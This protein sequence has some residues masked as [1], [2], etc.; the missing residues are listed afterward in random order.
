VPTAS[1]PDRFFVEFDTPE[2][3][4]LDFSDD[5]VIVLFFISWA[6]SAE[7]GGTHE[8]ALAANHL[9]RSLKVDV[10]PLYKYAD[11][12]IDTPQDQQEFDRAWQPASELAACI[13]TVADHW[14]QPDATLAPLIEGYLHL[15][16]R[17]RELAA[18]CD[19]AV[20]AGGADA[21]IRLTFDL[22][23]TEQHTPRP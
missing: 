22:E 8:L 3:C 12:N 4:P 13:R 1:W 18:M 20:E 23:N 19:W 15:A 21:K 17:L 14:E 2:A 9:K 11:R 16:P 10:R 7:M 5:P 6:Y